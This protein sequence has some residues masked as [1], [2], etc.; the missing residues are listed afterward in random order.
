M[1]GVG[2]IRV[3]EADMT[4][5]RWAIIA[6]IA[7]AAG[8]GIAFGP[9]TIASPDIPESERLAALA[10]IAAGV[11]KSAAPQER[12]A[13]IRLVQALPR[14]NVVEAEF[15][16]DASTAPL[17]KTAGLVDIRSSIVSSMCRSNLASGFHRGLVIHSVYATDDGNTVADFKVDAASCVG[18]SKPSAG[19]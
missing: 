1:L 13:H 4:G 17:F 18:S 12:T 10:R 11:I 5:I 15:L 6:I 2:L 7:A 16:V 8:A 3:L 14:E 19:Q 9:V